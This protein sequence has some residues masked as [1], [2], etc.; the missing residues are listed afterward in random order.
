MTHD[1]DATPAGS[2]CVTAVFDNDAD[3]R[4]ARAD[5]LAAGF[6]SADIEIGAGG[7]AGQVADQAPPSQGLL[8]TLLGIF[9]FMPAADRMT[10]EEA[11]RR[12]GVALS[13]RTGPERYEE[14]IDILDRDGAIDLDERQQSWTK[15]GWE[16]SAPPPAQ[17]QLDSVHPHDPLV[18]SAANADVRERIGT[19][20]ADMTAGTDID[21]PNA[22]SPGLRDTAHGR[23]RIRSYVSSPADLDPS[24]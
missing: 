9:V 23:R 15:D 8:S 21:P 13:V 6:G 4:K 19:G 1:I 7:P 3:A 10:Y 5:L 12:G 22:A 16:A 20:T 18:N 17:T 11:M 24:I 14:A 2:R